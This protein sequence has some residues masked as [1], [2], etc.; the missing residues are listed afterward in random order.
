MIG[1]TPI[2]SMAE[3]QQVM[4]TG[5]GQLSRIGTAKKRNPDNAY[6]T[7]NICTWLPSFLCRDDRFGPRHLDAKYSTN[8]DGIYL[9]TPVLLLV[10]AEVIL[11]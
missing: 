2:D 11:L 7:R 3:M 4:L 5:S 9:Q 1:V 8:A 6:L 10:N